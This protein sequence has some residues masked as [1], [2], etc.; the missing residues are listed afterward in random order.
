MDY[1]L[2]QAVS[3]GKIVLLYLQELLQEKQALLQQQQEDAW[4][5]RRLLHLVAA[6]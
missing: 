6:D 2:S 1:M 4:I 3:A 5:H